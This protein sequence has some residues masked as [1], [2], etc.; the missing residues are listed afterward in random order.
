MQIDLGTGVNKLT[1]WPPAATEPGS[2]SNV[3]T[4]IGGS[5]ADTVTYNT[6][7]SSRRLRRSRRRRQRHA[8]P[9]WPLRHQLRHGRPIPRRSPA[10]TGNDTVTLS[11]AVASTA[12]SDR[13]GHR[14]R[15]TRP[16][17]LRQHRHRLQCRDSGRRHRGRYPHPAPPCSPADSVDLGAGGDRLTL[18]N[19]TNIRHGQPTSKRIVRRH[20]VLTP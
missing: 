9:A 12:M 16:R 10:A 2:V 4:L 17:Q 5:G 18:A 7:V 15:Q 11:T 14:R 8:D 13:S 20:Q 1:L 3:N 19:G 6:A